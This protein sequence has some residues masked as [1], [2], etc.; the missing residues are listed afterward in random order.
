MIEIVCI[1][2]WLICLRAAL[3]DNAIASGSLFTSPGFNYVKEAWDKGGTLHMIGLLRYRAG[4]EA[5]ETEE[6][7]RCLPVAGCQVVH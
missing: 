5:R 2:V 1:V 6:R 4:L 3:V 7:K